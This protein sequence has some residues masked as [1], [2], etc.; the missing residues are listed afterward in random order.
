MVVINKIYNVRRIHS[1]VLWTERCLTDN[2]IIDI[3]ADDDTKVDQKIEARGVF[4]SELILVAS[5]F[6][7]RLSSW[8]ILIY[9]SFIVNSVSFTFWRP[10]LHPR[11][12]LSA[13]LSTKLNVISYRR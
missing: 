9:W 5:F 1:F 2:I 11:T 13:L 6:E 12:K 3:D 7:I 4:D 10:N 8:L